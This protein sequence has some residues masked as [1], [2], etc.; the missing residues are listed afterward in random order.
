[1]SKTSHTQGREIGGFD[2]GYLERLNPKEPDFLDKYIEAVTR[3][4]AIKEQNK[5]KK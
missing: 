5:G 4:K 2:D 1:M 3:P